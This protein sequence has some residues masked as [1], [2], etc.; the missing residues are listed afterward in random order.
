MV[1]Q[2]GWAGQ[3]RSPT[4]GGMATL[5]R[6]QDPR[7]DRVPW[8]PQAWRQALY[9]AGGIPAQLIALFIVLAWTYGLRWRLNWFPVVWP[10]SWGKLSALAPLSLIA[11]F[12][13]V[14]AFTAM[15]R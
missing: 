10:V 13:A 7:N 4:V 1:K 3:A 5:A 15:H 9:L 8:S 11:V 6:R 2:A 12:L 14:P